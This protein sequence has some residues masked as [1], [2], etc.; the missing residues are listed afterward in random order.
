MPA[1]DIR[2]VLRQTEKFVE[3]RRSSTRR[4]EAVMRAGRGVMTAGATDEESG[5][6]IAAGTTDD[7]AQGDSKRYSRKS[8][9][10][11][12]CRKSTNNINGEKQLETPPRTWVASET[13]T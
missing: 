6:V 9:E 3:S 4:V 11:T 13:A 8:C 7:K 2:T 12:T 1:K 5:L 10:K